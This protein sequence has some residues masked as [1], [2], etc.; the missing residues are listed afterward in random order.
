M[1]AWM[2]V[3]RIKPG[4]LADFKRGWRAGPGAGTVDPYSGVTAV[5]LLE[6]VNDPGRMI[7]LGVFENR[8]AYDRYRASEIEADRQFAIAP[9]VEAVEEERWFE[10]TS[11][12][13]IPATTD[14]LGSQ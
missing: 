5:L 3:R 4:M 11:Y 12:G 13:S 8:Q 10:L 6:D 14:L 1:F 9:Y 2:T 7:G